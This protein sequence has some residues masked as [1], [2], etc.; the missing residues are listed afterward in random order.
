MALQTFTLFNI[1]S[2]IVATPKQ[3]LLIIKVAGQ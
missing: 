3:Y 2:L 1:A